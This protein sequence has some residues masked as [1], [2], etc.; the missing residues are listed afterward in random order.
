MTEEIIILTAP[1]GSGKTELL[2]ELA[3]HFPIE[4]ISADSRQIFKYMNIGTAKI[5]SDDNLKVKH[6]LIDIIN[7]DENYNAGKFE[8]DGIKIINE[9]KSR[10]KIPI[11]AG[12]TGFYIK[13][14]I[15]GMEDDKLDENEK[16]IVRN[17]INNLRKENGDKYII[18]ELKKLDKT[19]HDLYQGQ[20]IRRISRALEYF[21]I[22]GNS[23]INLEH[24]SKSNFKPKYFIL[25]TQRDILYNQINKRTIQMWDNG[26]EQEVINLLNMGYG[27]H[28]YALNS[29]G[30]REAIAFLENRITKDFAISEMQKFTRHYAKRQITWINNQNKNEFI[31]LADKNEILK[32]LILECENYTKNA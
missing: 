23:I 27:L 13:A 17:K 8:N 32:Y 9:I 29:V 14:L 4:I 30:Y 3:K 25:Q 18:E 20:N 31:S 1:T 16:L 21:L 22:T 11:V 12:G 2:I 7:P 26:F 6:H 5:S 15:Q 28:N 10:K 24:F 19:A